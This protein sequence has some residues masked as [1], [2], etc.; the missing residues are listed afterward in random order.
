M[1]VAIDDAIELAIDDASDELTT[2]AALDWKCWTMI[3]EGRLAETR[4]LA[5]R[6]ADDTEPRLSRATPEQLSGWGRFL[7]LAST[8]AVRDNRPGE[9]ADYLKLARVAAAAVGRDIIPPSNPWQVFGSMTISM[10]HAE[11]AMIQ[12]QP[13]VVLMDSNLP[14][15][16]L[17]AAALEEI[18]AQFPKFRIWREAIC[19]RTRYVARS[20]HAGLNPH[21]V[22]TGDLA[23]LRAALSGTAPPR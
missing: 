8:A 21:T 6:W 16:Q 3:R 5:A 15:T 10:I 2:M 18:R 17:A 22:V 9:A 20:Q 7:V 23:E 13:D 19:D 12:D 1:S 11:N 14:S 4:E